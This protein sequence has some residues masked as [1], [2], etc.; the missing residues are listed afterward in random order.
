MKPAVYSVI[1]CGLFIAI[2]SQTASASDKVSSQP[3]SIVATNA[4]SGGHL[5]I[6]RSPVLGKNVTITVTIDGKVTGS[7]V[8]G[9]T[10][11]EYVV[12]GRHVLL[13]SPNRLGGDWHGTIDVRAGETYIFVAK[14]NVDQLILERV[15]A[16][17]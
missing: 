11:D 16:A 1:L 12:P 13:A 2:A 14:Y 5:I 3:G 15:N 9:H 7:L 4:S 6:K 8:R 17:R 10:F